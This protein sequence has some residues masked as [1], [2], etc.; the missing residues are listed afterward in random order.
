M[1][2]EEA[3]DFLQDWK[4]FEMALV[5]DETRET[6]IALAKILIK[7]LELFGDVV[8]LIGKNQSVATEIFKIFSRIRK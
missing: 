1:E 4:D 2:D 6:A 3:S 7:D 8:D 5:R